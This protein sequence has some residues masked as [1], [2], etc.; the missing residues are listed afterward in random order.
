MRKAEARPTISVCIPYYKGERTICESVS[1]IYNQTIKSRLS[2]VRSGEVE[3]IITSD[4]DSDDALNVLG[5]IEEV[6]GAKVFMNE[7]R[8]G[9]AGNSQAALSKGR[10]TIVTLMHQDDWCAPGCLEA[11]VDRF[12]SDPDIVLA[13][14]DESPDRGAG[15]RH[16]TSGDVR[17]NAYE[18][19]AALETMEVAFAPSLTFMRGDAVRSQPALYND[20]YH[21]SPERELYYNIAKD[22][23]NM[24]FN[25]MDGCG[26]VRRGLSKQHSVKSE[27]LQILDL[28]TFWD[29]VARSDR[30]KTMSLG[31]STLDQVLAR[32][33]LWATSVSSNRPDA[34]VNGWRWLSRIYADARFSELIELHPA[35]FQCFVR[36]LARDGV[37]MGALSFDCLQRR[38]PNSPQKNAA[39]SLLRRALQPVD[40]KRRTRT[41][42]DRIVADDQFNLPIIICGFHHSGTRLL[43]QVLERIGVFQQARPPKHEWRYVQQLN[44]ILLPGWMDPDAIA[45]FDG[46][47]GPDVIAPDIL[48]LRLSSAGYVRGRPWGQKDPR[49][50][51]TAAAWLK[52][53]PHARLVNI[54]RNPMDALGTLAKSYS[55]FSPGGLLPQQAPE[56]WSRLW[57]SYLN[58]TRRAMS[59]ADR[60]IEIKFEDLCWEPL[61]V[62]LRIIEALELDC[63]ARP[64]D[65]SDLTFTPSKIGSHLDWIVRG[66]LGFAEA[67]AI[68]DRTAA[69]SLEWARSAGLRHGAARA[70]A[71][72]KPPGDGRVRAVDVQTQ[73]PVFPGLGPSRSGG[74]RI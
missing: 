33:D 8:L 27:D 1:S 43:A 58:A 59:R 55:Q 41:R 35:K 29:R 11:V 2:A 30:Q 21:C 31:E 57:C 20:A 46:A 16:P 4:D 52:V 36:G 64:R 17:R 22:R 66:E 68:R 71:S 63:T 25:V 50:S 54:V 7:R 56:F 45:A 49:N 24:W 39:V 60:A 18:V 67:D 51:V 72:A 13:A 70:A 14:F 23:P 62:A 65:F 37:N 74:N 12:A 42:V 47:S 38:L 34:I 32:M 40:R 61:E 73:Q 44:T 9:L 10:G 26:L 5:Q 6:F 48:A 3:V 69:V 19:S 28:L 15:R 53:F